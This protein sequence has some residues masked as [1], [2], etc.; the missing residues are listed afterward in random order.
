VARH[1]N[2]FE[3]EPSVTARTGLGSGLPG[4]ELG[5]NLSRAGMLAVVVLALL[6]LT[7]RL[8]AGRLDTAVAALAV[9]PMLVT[10]FQSYGG[11]GPL[12]V[13]L[14]ALPWL[15]F[16]AAAACRPAAR[17]RTLL[18][19]SWR[20][21]AVTALVGTATLFGYFG[22]E[23]T[24]YMTRD[25]VAVSRWYLDHAPAGSSM[26]LL[27]P[28][29]PER[30]NAR[31]SRQLEEP[32]SV[33]GTPDMRRGVLVPQRLLVCGGQCA[34]LVGDGLRRFL[35]ADRAPAH[36]LV[37]SPVQL[38]YAR[39]YGLADRAAFGRFTGALLASPDYRL[40]YRH[41]DGYVFRLVRA[42]S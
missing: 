8:R 26:T 10:L 17:A 23:P 18:G 29:F 28:D 31:Y 35:L 13:Y 36:Y 9:G 14:F 7:R 27:A 20:L 19:R 34:L 5:A 37:V 22:Q 25:D 32:R 38:R 21:V 3:F 42:R 41:G 2:L 24:N 11:E 12:R 4:V 40:D 1:F 6:G 15:A 39:Y 16:F 33:L 30:L